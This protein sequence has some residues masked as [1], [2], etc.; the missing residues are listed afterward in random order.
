MAD[1]SEILDEVKKL[2]KKIDD[3][4]EQV[5]VFYTTFARQIN[6]IKY[7]VQILERAMR[8]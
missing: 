8:K 5:N 1:N 3:Y 7:N 2:S 4:S 6:Q